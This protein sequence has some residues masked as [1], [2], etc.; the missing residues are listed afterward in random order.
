VVAALG[1]RTGT[2]MDSFRRTR[3]QFPRVR[4]AS[5]LGSVD[6]SVID[7][8]GGRSGPYEGSYVT[9]WYPVSTD[10]R[11]DQMRSVINKEAFGDN[12]VDPTDVGVQTTWIAYT[13]LR[14]AVESLGGGEV[15]AQTVRRALDK[16]LRVGTGG[17]TPVLSW[18]FQDMLADSDFPRL[19]NADVTCQTVRS[20]RLTAQRGGFVNMASTLE[21]S[22]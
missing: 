21:Q 11:W 18:R 13:V 9:G 20:G 6:Q 17:L 7:A 1:D 19:V 8:T 3:Q 14:K 22:N 16:G 5:V 10:K 12:R 4:T 2:F 15:S